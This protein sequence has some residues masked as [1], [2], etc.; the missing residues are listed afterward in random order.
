VPGAPALD[1]SDGPDDRIGGGDVSGRFTAVDIPDHSGDNTVFID[2]NRGIAVMGDALMGADIRGMPAGYVI[3]P[4]EMWS[5]DLH[6]AERNLEKLLD[7]E[8]EIALVNHG[9]SVFERASE[10]LER[11]VNFE[12][13]FT[14]GD[15]ASIHSNDRKTIQAD[16]LYN[17]IERE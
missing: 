11:Y 2:E 3:L 4:P 6:E 7:Y 5:E 15:G 1:A 12:S 17:R 10:K 14:S 9:S 16:D 13:N 8:F